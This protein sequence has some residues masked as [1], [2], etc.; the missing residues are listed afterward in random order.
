MADEQRT[1]ALGVQSLVFRAFGSIPGPIVFGVIFDSACI[2]WQYNCGRQGNCWVYDNAALSQRAVIMAVMGVTLNFIFSFLTWIFYPKQTQ[3]EKEAH[4]IVLNELGEITPQA[5]P[6]ETERD[7][8]SLESSDSYVIEGPQSPPKRR[9]SSNRF[10]SHCSE[11]VLLDYDHTAIEEGVVLQDLHNARACS[12][13]K[14]VSS[15]KMVVAP[16]SMN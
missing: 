12:V 14:E 9:R 8:S 16:P 4:E 3:A 6:D 7:S 13:E 2:F 1:L 11:D 15:P 5:M 10:E